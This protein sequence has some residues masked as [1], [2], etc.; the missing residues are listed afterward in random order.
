MTV[1]MSNAKTVLIAAMLVTLFAGDGLAQ[2]TTGRRRRPEAPAPTPNEG[3]KKKS[4]DSEKFEDRVVTFETEDGVTIEADW[5]PVKVKDGKKSPVAILIHMYPAT[6]T[7]WEP[8]EPLLR[9]KLGIAVLAYDIRGTGGSVKPEDRDLQT[10][11]QDRDKEHFA[12]AW[13]D[14]KAAFEWLKKQDH[15]DTDR[16]I[17]IGASV[18]CSIAIEFAS[19][20]SAIKGVACLSPGTNYME[21]DS[22]SHIKDV[23]KAKVLLMSPDGEYSAIEELMEAGKGKAAIKGKKYLGGREN[24]GTKMFDAEYGDEVKQRLV[25]FA[26]GVLDIDHE[27]PEKDKPKKEE[28]APPNM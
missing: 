6:R 2:V 11:Y 8:L 28:P 17:I 1:T 13:L 25:R 23:G 24:H 12:N 18:G 21:I 27:K 5:Y 15:I 16:S 19:K 20:E 4:D 7:S 3:D 26:A 22:L 9:K 10:K 14:T